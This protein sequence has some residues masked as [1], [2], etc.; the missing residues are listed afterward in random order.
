M[1]T[2]KPNDTIR[3][4]LGWRNA[5]VIGVCAPG[6]SSPMFCRILVRHNHA[7]AYAGAARHSEQREGWLEA[8]L[9]LDPAQLVKGSARRNIAQSSRAV[10]R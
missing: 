8:K 6:V 2:E 10:F 5:D 3:E 4:L 1:K 7:K 9:D